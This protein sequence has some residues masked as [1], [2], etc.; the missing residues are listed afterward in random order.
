MKPWLLISTIAILSSVH[1]QVNTP[2]PSSAS[3]A[4]SEFR[5]QNTS[6]NYGLA[7]VKALIKTLKYDQDG[8]MAITAK[9]WSALSVAERFTYTMIHGEDENQNCDDSPPIID[10]NLK[11]FAYTPPVF[12]DER[13]WSKRQ[14]DYLANN[15][16]AIIGLLRQTMNGRHRAGTNLKG[17]I[18]EINAFE[19]VPDLIT[20][21]KRDR[22]D[23]DLLTTMMV[24]M[25]NAKYPEFMVSTTW[26]KLFGPESNYQAYISANRANQDLIMKR[27]ANF[28]TWKKHKH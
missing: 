5:H 20:L 15:R 24:L 6:P 4:Y 14:R 23:H 9:Q 27:A 19:L 21:Y 28:V 17:T 11:I 8:G 1:G 7:K 22:K 13:M 16:G 25:D 18:Q 10:E 2:K 12:D 3:L 26:T